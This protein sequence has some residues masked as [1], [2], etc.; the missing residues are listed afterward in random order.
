MFFAKK[1]RQKIV[2][3]VLKGL[4]LADKKGNKLTLVKLTFSMNGMIN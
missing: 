4:D 1:T 3:K 2:G